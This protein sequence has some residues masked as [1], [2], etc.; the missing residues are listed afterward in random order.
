MG[1]FMLMALLAAFSGSAMAQQWVK[2]NS[3]AVEDLYV[4]LSSISRARDFI[5]M[6]S[7]TDYKAEQIRGSGV[8]YLSAKMQGQYNCK[9]GMTRAVSIRLHMQNMGNGFSIEGAVPPHTWKAKLPLT[10]EENFWRF[11]CA[12]G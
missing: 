11:A 8:R 10:P 9:N 1:K 12:R 7:L 2:I 4:D 6:T 3:S 5:H